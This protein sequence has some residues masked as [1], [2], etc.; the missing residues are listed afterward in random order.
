M[1]HNELL[2]CS[3]CGTG[4]HHNTQENVAYGEKPY[5]YD[6]GYGMCRECGGDD[7]VAAGKKVSEM[8]EAQF[9]KRLGWGKQVFFE[10]RFDNVRKNLSPD[11]QEKWDKLDYKKKVYF[12][13]KLVEEGKMI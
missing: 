4:V 12:V 11:N 10:A 2:E 9:K 5:P 7:N 13:T 6:T 8:T 1:D 3:C